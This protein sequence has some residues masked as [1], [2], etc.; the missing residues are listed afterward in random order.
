MSKI[1]KLFERLSRFFRFLISDSYKL[2]NKYQNKNQITNAELILNLLKTKGFTPKYIIDVG[3]GY[4]Q[5]TK[6]LFK[7]YPSSNYL[8]FDADKNNKKK[9]DILK[10]NNNML[11]YKICLL[12]NDNKTYKFYNMG[13]GSSIFEE[14][15]SHKREV[16]EIISTTLD[17]EIPAE[18]KKYSNNLIKL[19]VQGAELMIL[20]GLKDSINLFEVIILEVSLHNYNKNSPLFNDVIKYMNDKNFKLYDLFDLKRLGSND[21]FLVQ[22]DCVFARNNSELLN[23][24]F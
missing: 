15:T 8:L 16:E 13:Y 6:K 2:N 9:L 18:L 11:D 5:W 14:Q 1:N 17:E 23:V 24:K 19:D 10:K 4:G 3:C 22:F 7:F 12:S 21:S 20:D